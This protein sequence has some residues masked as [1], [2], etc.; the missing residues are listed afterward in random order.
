MRRISSTVTTFYKKVFPAI[1]FG[2]LALS[3][4]AGITKGT[5]AKGG[6]AVL[7]VVPCIMGVVGYYLIRRLVWD[8]ADEVCDAG[9]YL[10]VRNAGREQHLPLTDIMNVSVSMAV[11][12]PRVTLKLTGASSQGPLG[13]EVAFSP[14]RP[15]TLNPFAKSEIVEDLIVR[16]DRAR[17]KRAV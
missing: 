6:G 4:I 7:L 2:F 3:L 12:P 16:V 15:F 17:S 8:L 13:K 1:W 10:I 14:E 9:D 11:N 5:Y